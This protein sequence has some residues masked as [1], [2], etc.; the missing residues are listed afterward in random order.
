MVFADLVASMKTRFLTQHTKKQVTKQRVL[1][2]SR[3]YFFCETHKTQAK[4]M[5]FAH[6]IAFAKRRFYKN[7]QKLLQNIG[8][9][10]NCDFENYGEM[11]KTLAKERVFLAARKNEKTK[12]GENTKTTDTFFR[13]SA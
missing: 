13:N 1:Q 6:R 3:F 12:F 10:R 4:S 8:F 11:Q 2:Q 7:L 5:V 9:Y